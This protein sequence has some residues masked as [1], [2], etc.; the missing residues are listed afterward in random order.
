[1]TAEHGAFRVILW[2]RIK[3]SLDNGIEKVYRVA[4]VVSERARIE[5]AVAKLLIEKGGLEAKQ[6]KAYKRL[7]ER[8]YALWEQ[9]SESIIGDPE[10]A[11][12]LREV[13]DLKED[14]EAIRQNINTVSLGEEEP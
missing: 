11:E 8:V 1:M 3:K 12:S 10:V 9:K 13:T 6:E 14:I 7:G 2:D 4:K 5:A